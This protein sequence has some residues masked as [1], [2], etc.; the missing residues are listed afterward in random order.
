MKSSVI[1][2]SGTGGAGR[3][4]GFS[5]D[6]ARAAGG[7]PVQQVHWKDGAAGD[8]ADGCAAVMSG[9]P[10]CCADTC[11]QRKGGSGTDRGMQLGGKPGAISADENHL[12]GGGMEAAIRSVVNHRRSRDMP[13]C[14]GSVGLGRPFTRTGPAAAGE[15]IPEKEE[16]RGPFERRMARKARAASGASSR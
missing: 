2:F 7:A 3:A 10:A 11:R 4:A 16:R 5:A 8:V 1:Y 9:A 12:Y 15:H 6:G 13:A 14:S